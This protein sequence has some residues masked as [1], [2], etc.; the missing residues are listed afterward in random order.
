MGPGYR[1]SSTAP[2]GIGYDTE[3]HTDV[4]GGAHM[5]A[6]RGGAD[7]GCCSV[8]DVSGHVGPRRRAGRHA[9][10]R[11]GLQVVRGSSSRLSGGRRLRCSAPCRALPARRLGRLGGRAILVIVPLALGGRCQGALA[12]Q[13]VR[14]LTEAPADAEQQGQNM[15]AGARDDTCCTDVRRPTALAKLRL[16]CL[17]EGLR[18]ALDIAL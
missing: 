4:R 11:H 1:A 14:R 6:A 5:H 18:T 15:Y 8:H 12:L 9:C 13:K 16:V 17:P 3:L 10:I 2:F 7:E